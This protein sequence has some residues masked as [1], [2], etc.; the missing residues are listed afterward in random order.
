MKVK[1]IDEHLKTTEH[2]H[3]MFVITKNEDFSSI[4]NNITNTCCYAY[5][6][7]VYILFL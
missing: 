2:K 6:N 4:M 3:R 7:K 5:K 1:V